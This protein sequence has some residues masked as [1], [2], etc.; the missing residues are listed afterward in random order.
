[1]D[2]VDFAAKI[3]KHK[4]P[5]S[6]TSSGENLKYTRS[7]TPSPTMTTTVRQR[8]K[9]LVDMKYETRGRVAALMQVL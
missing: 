6:R 5:N 2:E 7:M 1:M 3:H 9:K 4:R 8:A